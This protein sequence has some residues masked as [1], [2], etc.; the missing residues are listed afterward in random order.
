MHSSRTHLMVGSANLQFTKELWLSD[1]KA[2]FRSEKSLR[3]HP[4]PSERLAENRS[5]LKRRV[6]IHKLH[7]NLVACSNRLPRVR[8]RNAY[9]CISNFRKGLIVAFQDFAIYRITLLWVASVEI[10]W[11]SA[12]HGIDVIKTVI[13][14]AAGDLNVSLSLAAKKQACYS[15]GLNRS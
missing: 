15:H 8:S 9:Q 12:E 14:Y 6:L 11:L 2:P 10:Q 7:L 1:K 5:V 3:I 13:R 4:V